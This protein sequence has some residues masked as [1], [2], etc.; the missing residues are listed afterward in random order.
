MTPRP[1][2][3]P[4]P[5]PDR[6]NLYDRTAPLADVLDSVRHRTT[7]IRGA[8]LMGKTSLL[9]VVALEV[10]GNG[11]FAMIRLAPVDTRIAFMAEILD[12]IQHWVDE[13]R[14]GPLHSAVPGRGRPA[15]L[16]FRPLS[17]RPVPEPEHHSPGTIAQ[18]CQRIARLAEHVTG[19]VFL[20]CV[21]EFDSL[22]QDWDEHEARLVLELISHLDAM[23]RLPVRFLLTMSTIPALALTSFRSPIFNQAKIVTLAPWDAAEAGKFA[24]WL[25]KDRVTFD[26][27]ALATLFAAAGGHPY[28]TKA[29]LNALL[30]GPPGALESRQV[31]ATQVTAAVRAAARSPE[32]DVA[33]ENLVRVHLSADA[34]AILDRAGNSQAGVSGRSL[35]DPQPGGQ[36]LSSLQSGLLRREG[37]RYLLRLGLWREWRAATRGGR[38]RPPL[39]HRIGRTASRVRPRRPT[40]LMLLSAVAGP[41]LATLAT[42]AYL[43]P[44]RT[45]LLRPCGNP[46]AE[47]A[48]RVA[49]PDFASSGESREAEVLVTNE[50][51]QA[52]ADGRVLLEFPKG[53]HATGQNWTGLKGLFPGEQKRLEVT[54]S[55][56]QAGWLPFSA[57]RV[58]V[59]LEVT[60]DGGWA[61]TWSIGVAPIP[62][63]Q[64]IRKIAG[65][66]LLVFLIPF[67][68]PY[69]VEYVSRRLVRE[70]RGPQ[71]AV[72]TAKGH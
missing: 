6:D 45:V 56:S 50:G 27:S 3:F 70:R 54:F 69:A 49:L 5:V 25:A 64:T 35:N 66:V 34:V 2:Y 55:T 21:D 44:G 19:V 1:A 47:L 26:E 57:A 46:G 52:E 63:L 60:A 4:D 32:V 29:V 58:K 24:E 33:L 51:Q 14:S 17:R 68:I 10:E 62:R 72:G 18:F 40:T 12:G 23:P 48:C 41:L 61:R 43:A 9:N 67:L 16:G 59:R 31:S 71:A 38:A 39:L 28:F 11:K 30:G 42:T 22:I 65:T 15:G 37:D 53:A 8:R 7:V 20:L 36:V 13:H